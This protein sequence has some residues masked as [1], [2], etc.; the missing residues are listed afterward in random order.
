MIQGHLKGTDLLR[1]GL[2]GGGDVGDSS[3]AVAD[4]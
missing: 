3:L 4:L 2:R 1:V